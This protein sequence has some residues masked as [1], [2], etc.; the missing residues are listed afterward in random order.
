MLNKLHRSLLF[1][2]VCTPIRVL[3]AWIPVLFTLSNNILLFYGISLYL[4]G[5]SFL[6]LYFGNYRLKAPEGGG[7][8]WW[9]SFRIVHGIL[10]CISGLLIILKWMHPPIG[11]QNYYS[12]LHVSQLLSLDIVF[13]LLLFFYYELS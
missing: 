2:L 3:I 10:Y 8:T 1:L 12:L 7:H 5:T 11:I 9:S 4:I 6:V 13:G